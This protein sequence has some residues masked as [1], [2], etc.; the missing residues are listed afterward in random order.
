MANKLSSFVNWCYPTS[1][2]VWSFLCELFTALSMMLFSILV[3]FIIWNIEINSHL[4]ISWYLHLWFWYTFSHFLR[5]ITLSWML[6]HPQLDHH[7]VLTLLSFSTKSRL[8][9]LIIQIYIGINHWKCWVNPLNYSNLFFT[10]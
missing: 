2:L 4:L 7:R 5:S 3:Y 8:F 9:Q 10:L 6:L 1:D